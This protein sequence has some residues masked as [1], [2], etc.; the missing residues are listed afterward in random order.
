MN[1]PL[2]LLIFCLL[3]LAVSGAQAPLFPAPEPLGHF[4]AADPTRFPAA[5]FQKN[6]CNEQNPNCWDEFLRSGM[7]W[8]ADVDDDHSAEL[9]VYPGAKNTGAGDPWYFLYHRA[10]E[11]WR[12]VAETEDGEGWQTAAPRFDVLPAAQYGHHDLRVAVDRCLKWT[13]EKYVDYAPR[14]YRTLAPGWF[15]TEDNH[16]AEIF[17]AIRYSGQSVV[18][19]EP[20]WFAVVRAEFLQGEKSAS[21]VGK[22]MP[23]TPAQVLEDPQQQIT[24]VALA[25]GG[26]WGIRSDRGFLL[27]PRRACAGTSRLAIRGDWL[28]A[29][30]SSEVPSEDERPLLRYNRRTHELILDAEPEGN[31]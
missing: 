5:V 29:Y 8:A 24:W 14:D 17:W 1:R 13:G 11:T 7:L 20:Q 21:A 9:L 19:L 16:E 28:L 15:N 6:F 25:R 12:S 27:A 26:I 3:W 31:R 23:R 18:S 22:D 30:E 4:A 2:A 10:G